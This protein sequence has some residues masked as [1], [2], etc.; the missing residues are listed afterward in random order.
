MKNEEK[1]M[2]RERLLSQQSF[3][4]HTWIIRHDKVFRDKFKCTVQAMVQAEA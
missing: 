3:F 4:R 2:K 1:K